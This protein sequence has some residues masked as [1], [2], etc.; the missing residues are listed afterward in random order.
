MAEPDTWL[1]IQKAGLL[2]TATI[3][4][5]CGMTGKQRDALEL[6]KRERKVPIEH[7]TL[8][9]IILRDQKPL[10]VSKLAGSLTDCTIEQWLRMLNNRVFFWPT[11]E[12]LETLMSAREYAGHKHLVLT[13]ETLPLVQDCKDNITLTPMNTGNTQPIAHERGLETFSK[14]QDYPF[15]ERLK[16]GPY[17]TVVEVAVEGGVPNITE[18]V[19]K[20]EHAV[21]KGSEIQTLEV[22]FE[23]K[24]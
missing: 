12:R 1:K 5:H 6:Q 16:R 21:Y 20:A 13:V 8:G 7:P 10:I 4:D 23:R 22:L 11:W 17:Y 3:L 18:Y 2:S 15:Q 19:V 24:T 9:T 14:M